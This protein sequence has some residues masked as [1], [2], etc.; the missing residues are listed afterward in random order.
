MVHAWLPYDFIKKNFD[1]EL[2]F[3]DTESLTYEIKSEGVFEEFFKHKHLFDFSNYP[4][5]SKFFGQGNKNV[6]GKM[7]DVPEGK[8]I[9]ELVGLKSQKHSMKIN[10]GK[11]S[12]R[13]KLVNI[14]TEFNKFKDILFN[15]NL[16]RH[17]MRRIQGKNIRLKH[18]KSTKYHYR[19]L[20]TEY[21][22]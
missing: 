19:I 4:K 21:L 14:A 9:N 18:A 11:E 6:I 16:L 7:K 12:K 1:T 2:L 22:S 10:D 3:T 17:R 8:K 20:M 13:A 5:D 15:K